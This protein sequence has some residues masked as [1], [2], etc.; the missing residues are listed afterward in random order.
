V[1]RLQA[2]QQAL[3]EGPLAQGIANAFGG[4]LNQPTGYSGRLNVSAR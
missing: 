3:G 1:L 4:L 2:A